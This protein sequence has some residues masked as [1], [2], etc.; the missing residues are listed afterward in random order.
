MCR[1]PL[2]RFLGAG[3]ALAILVLGSGYLRR[4]HARAPSTL[5]EAAQ[6]A[7]GLGLFYRSDRADGR[8]QG[9][10]MVSDRTVTFE[11][12]AGTPLCDP[13]DRR[14]VGTVVIY[15]GWRNLNARNDAT[16]SAVWGEL[17]VYGDPNFIDRLIH[18]TP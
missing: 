18:A 2:L 15:S 9:R 4:H 13:K 16:C 7:E 6:I 8:L 14:W 1:R 17:L 11:R 10:L 3:L 12:A 5:V